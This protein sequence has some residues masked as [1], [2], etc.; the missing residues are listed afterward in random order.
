MEPKRDIM[1]WVN[2]FSICTIAVCEALHRYD[3][4]HCGR[5]NVFTVFLLQHQVAAALIRLMSNH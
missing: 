4:A 1:F 5:R 3:H 2:I